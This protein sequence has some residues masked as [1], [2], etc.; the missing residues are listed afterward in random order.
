MRL[1]TAE[2]GRVLLSGARKRISRKDLDMNR[3]GSGLLAISLT[4]GA[5][6]FAFAADMPGGPM[7][8][9]MLRAPSAIVA[10]NWD[11]FYVGGHVGAG[12]SSGNYTLNNGVFSENFAFDSSA[13]VGGGQMGL[14]AQWG[15]WVIGVEGSYTWSGYDETKTSTVLPTSLA[16]MD[17]KNL[18][19]ISGRLG[20]AADRL[21]IY[22][23]AGWAFARIHTFDHD[24]ASGAAATT[25]AWDNGYTL[26][27]GLEY[28]LMPGWIAGLAFDY[29][30][31]TPAR[32]FIIGA[33]TGGISGADIGLYTLTARL[34]YLFNWS[35]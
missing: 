29:Y 31:F 27:L 16:T 21:L 7:G 4:F 20:W 11:G 6:P 14:Q 15:H 33:G 22:G 35:R 18:G 10:A 12:W 9:S 26:G 32:T 25:V 3:I 30:N 28:Q 13:F 23:K 5:A 19:A 1:I 8:V 24:A 17:I 34:T 2:C